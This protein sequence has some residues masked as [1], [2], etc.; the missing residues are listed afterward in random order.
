VASNIRQ[1]LL[2][3]GSGSSG[4]GDGIAAPDT[5]PTR[6]PDALLDW[7]LEEL[8]EVF[9][10][11]LLPKLG[12][13][14]LGLLARTGSAVRAAVKGSGLPRVGDSEEVAPGMCYPPFHRHALITLL[15]SHDAFSTLLRFLRNWHPMTRRLASNICQ[16]VARHAIDTL[17]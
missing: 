6:T 9:H 5:S 8:P 16:P 2:S 3:G 13:L 11:V 17:L 4:G 15:A 10:G 1:A 12:T 7:L 14:D